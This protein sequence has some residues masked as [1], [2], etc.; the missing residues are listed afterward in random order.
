[1]K[2]RL[3]VI[4]GIGIIVFFQMLNAQTWQS[5]KRITDNSGWSGEAAIT[6]VSSNNIHVAWMD[7]TP[8]EFEIFYQRSTDGGSSWTQKRLSW[9]LGWSANPAIV[10]DSGNH[11]HV[12]W[13]DKTPG[14]ED[15]YYRMS[16]NGGANWAAVKRLTWS[17]GSSF[18]PSIAVDSSDNL[19]LAWQ[20]EAPGNIEI[21]YKKSTNGGSSWTTKRLTWNSG[22]SVRPEIAVDSSDN[23]HLV[24]RDDTSGN[25]E[26]YYK[27]S[28]NVGATWG[29]TKRLT[30]NTGLSI[31][32]VIATDS[33]N[34]IYVV[35]YD[36]SPGNWE[37]YNKK[38]TNGGGTWLGTRRL[39]WN[40]GSSLRPAVAVDSNGNIHLVWE[41]ESTGNLEIFFKRSTNGGSSWTTTRL[42]YNSGSSQYPALATDSSDNIHVVWKDSSPGYGEVYYKKGIQ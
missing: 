8:G 9:N 35:W 14:T 30:W 23:I 19:H 28:T 34:N 11:V 36:S 20:D 3:T 1:M 27:K 16:T 39:T 41:E 32:P 31:V 25:R 10:V 2:K 5:T 13:D 21:Y 7:D 37:L 22:S 24:W 29:L 42:S 4:T 40:S 18:R 15:I 38:S 12:V 33:S 6:I 17:S 26:I